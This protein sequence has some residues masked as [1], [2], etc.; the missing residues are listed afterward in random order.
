MINHS[1]VASI[2]KVSHLCETRI[3]TEINRLKT[4]N[5]TVNIENPEFDGCRMSGGTRIQ[6]VVVKGKGEFVKF[7]GHL[8][9][10]T[11][12]FSS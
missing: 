12:D 8:Y 7:V 6:H 10:Y 4:D 11:N 2:I 5:G 9:K 1:Q 3:K